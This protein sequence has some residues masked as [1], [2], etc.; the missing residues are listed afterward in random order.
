MILPTRVCDRVLVFDH[1]IGH[2]AVQG[3]VI[4]ILSSI[5]WS[6]SLP[7]AVA[8]WSF[9][10]PSIPA[11][12]DVGG[13]DGTITGPY[14]LS[15]AAAPVAGNVSAISFDGTGFV[16]IPDHP[17]FDFDQSQP[18]SIALWFKQ[19]ALPG[20]VV[21][22]IG[23]RAGCVGVQNINYQ[24]ARDSSHELSFASQGGIA[25]TGVPLQFNEWTH[26]AATYDGALTVQ[27]YL[28]GCL[29][30]TQTN[31]VLSGASDSALLIAG[32]GTCNQNFP[33]QIDEVWVFNRALT[34]VEVSELANATCLISKFCFGD[35]SN[36]TPCP[37]TQPDTVP[38][39]PAAL[40]HGCAN[41]QELNGALLSATGTT[42][43]DTIAFS[44]LI[45]PVY[46]G[47]GLMLK[48]N[49]NTAAGIASGD[50]LRCVDGQFVRFGAH[51][52]ATFGAAQGYW[53][54]PNTAQTNPVSV[55]TA[56]SPGE[57]AYYQL[58]Y[59]NAAAGFCNPATTNWSNG[60]RIMWP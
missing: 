9:D 6:Q 14:S 46:V 23:K 1:H 30:L 26:F 28:N 50:G 32:S 38:S 39:P 49:A 34:S 11:Q 51:H 17:A 42:V 15:A 54:Y 56:Q 21:H 22:M 24:L 36:P 10:N 45:S 33:G 2:R 5:A 13:F 52:A 29:V 58:F 55:Q 53:T 7:G 35:G 4:L 37:C 12:D 41:S 3:G 31:H 60:I 20:A 59:R 18:M 57:P 25:A 44:A 48:G 8:H 43:P 40:G 47:F 16:S 19:T 27:V